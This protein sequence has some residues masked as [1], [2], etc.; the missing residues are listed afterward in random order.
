MI[1]IGDAVSIIENNGVF[2]AKGRISDAGANLVFVEAFINSS[3]KVWKPAVS[4]QSKPNDENFA[5][6][7]YKV[8]FFERNRTIYQWFPPSQIFPALWANNVNLKI[9]ET[10][11][12]Q[13]FSSEPYKA[14]VEKLPVGEFGSFLVK[15]DG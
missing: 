4:D 12:S 13:L 5:P 15:H 9:G 14:V 1:E 8:G 3:K 2:K 10:V 6:K 7:A 11:Y